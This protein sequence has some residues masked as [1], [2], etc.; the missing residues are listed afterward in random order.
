MGR[1]FLSGICS[2]ST[3]HPRPN[4]AKQGRNTANQV[5]GTGI[6]SSISSVRQLFWILASCMMG[7]LV[8]DKIELPPETNFPPS[9]ASPSDANELGVGLD[10]IIRVN[11]DDPEAGSELVIPVIIRDANIQDDLS[12]QFLLDERDIDASI[13]QTI[14]ST[15]TPSMEVERDLTLRVPIDRFT[16]GC[17][18]LFFRV[19][20]EF[21]R[22]TDALNPALE[23]DLAEAVW[24]VR[25]VDEANLPVTLGSCR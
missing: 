3:L 24:W 19:S 25:V 10:Q 20:T 6:A 23:G 12:F 7:C 1:T 15:I 13:P 5:R 17:H 16:I 8:T 22:S 14:G 9:I 21:G 4:L 18:K 11:I 2:L